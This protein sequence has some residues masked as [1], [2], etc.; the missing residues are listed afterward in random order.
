MTDPQ[1]FETPAGYEMFQ[2]LLSHLE[3][4]YE[5]IITLI[6]SVLGFLF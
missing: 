2:W 5:L 6:A 1:L 4:E 3:N